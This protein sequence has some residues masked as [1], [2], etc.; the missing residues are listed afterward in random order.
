MSKAVQLLA[1]G[2]Q[3]AS[4]GLICGSQTPNQLPSPLP[5]S[6]GCSSIWVLWVFPPSCSF[7]FLT[8]CTGVQCS[9]DHGA[10]KTHGPGH[11]CRHG[12]VGKPVARKLRVQQSGRAEV[13][14][15]C[16]P[17]WGSGSSQCV[18]QLLKSW[19]T[20]NLNLDILN[21]KSIYSPSYI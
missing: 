9:A 6:F 10:R 12:V 18:A 19:A 2:L 4:K 7:H 1:L 14:M 13:C 17:V 15:A 11:S 16:S 3:V 5:H 21:L 20:L 8:P